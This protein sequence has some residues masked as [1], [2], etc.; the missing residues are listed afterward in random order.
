MILIKNIDTYSPDHIGRKD[1]LTIFDKI[2]YISEKVDLPSSNFPKAEIIDGSELRAIPGI[3]DLHVHIIGGGG[4]GGFT[5]RAP[6]LM[7]TQLTTN[8]VTTCI[9]LLGTDGTTRSMGNL[10]AKARSLEIEGLN[11]YVWTGSYKVPT[12]TITDSARGDIILVDKIIGIGEIAISD[13][14]S[15]HPSDEDLIHLATEARLGGMLSGK[16]GILHVHVGDGKNGITPL[17]N[18]RKN[19]EIPFSNI[20]PTHINRNHL[21]FNQA[22]E[23]AMDGGFVD[24]TT[25]IRPEGNDEVHPVEAFQELLKHNISPYQITMSSDSGGSS[26]I[27]DKSGNLIKFGIGSPSS[28]IEILQSCIKAGIPMEL[29][30]IPFTSSPAK[31]LKLNG[32]GSL[33]EGASSDIILLDKDLKIHSVICK[34]KLMVHN[35]KPIVFGAFENN[36]IC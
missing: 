29:A 22:I 7:L 28:N 21:V 4:E 12:R 1:I 15:S 33:S 20:L 13:H 8:G 25:S 3:I 26:P 24:I 32:K 16:C 27:F 9:G 5:S 14:R 11:T 10:I 19:S 36:R 18:I 23:Y 2:A 6:E 30:L 17:F 34:G 31:L 35:Y